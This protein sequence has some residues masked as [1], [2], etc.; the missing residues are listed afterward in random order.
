MRSADNIRSDEIG[1]RGL[2]L[3][4]SSPSGA[5]KTT[6][7]RRLLSGDPNLVMSV[8]ATTRLPRPSEVEGSDYFFLDK[9][10]FNILVNRGHMLEH[11]K[12]FD[13]Y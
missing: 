3:V 6:I 7:A 4:L 10:E 12:V 5:G 11:A 9:I 1:R 13:N 2:M 8:S